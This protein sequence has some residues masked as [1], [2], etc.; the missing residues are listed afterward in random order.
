VTSANHAPRN[1]AGAEHVDPDWQPRPWKVVL[2]DDDGDRITVRVEAAI[3]K[4]DAFNQARF[5][6][7][8]YVPLMAE[9]A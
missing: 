2:E 1:G 9:E 3:G 6:Q 4:R 8:F 5:R 7:P